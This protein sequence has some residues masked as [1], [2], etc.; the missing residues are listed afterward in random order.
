MKIHPKQYEAIV[1]SSPNMVWR[2]N[3]Q[4]ECDYFNSSWLRFTGKTMEEEVGLGWLEGVHPEDQERCLKT[5]SEAFDQRVPFNMEYR[6]RRYDGQYRWIND[7]G[8]PSYDRDRVFLGYVGSCMDIDEKIEGRMLKEVARQEQLNLISDVAS[9]LAH[10]IRNPL[11]TV[12]GFLQILT[13][14]EKSASFKE[15]FELMLSEI[16]K[17]NEIMTNFLYLDLNKAYKLKTGDLNNLV[18]QVLPLLEKY[19]Q[20]KGI[21]IVVEKNRLPLLLLDEKEIGMLIFNLVLNGIEAMDTGQLNIRTYLGENAVVLEVQ[22]QG[23]G[24]EQSVINKIGKPFV[25]T[26]TNK[27]GI[28]LAMCHSIAR[29]HNAEINFKTSEKGT[30]FYVYFTKIANEAGYSDSYRVVASTAI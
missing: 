27:V 4:K 30:T 28:G 8:T 7:R 19:Y 10:E 21:K 22:D 6:L 26:K 25:T 5:F 11:T 14:Q 9:G 17:A 18:L 23:E 20:Q 16:D 29:R 15:Y 24:I 1:E 2:A 12:R 13:Q 3:T